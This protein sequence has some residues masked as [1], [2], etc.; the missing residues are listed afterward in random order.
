M[1]QRQVHANEDDVRLEASAED[2]DDDYDDEYPEDQY[3]QEEDAE[4]IRYLNYS[5]VFRFLDEI[6]SFTYLLSIC[7]LALIYYQNYCLYVELEI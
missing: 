1:A 3:G 7:A 5:F 6:R 2:Y 4:V